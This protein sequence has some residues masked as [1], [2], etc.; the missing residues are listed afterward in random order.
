LKS[1]AAALSDDELSARRRSSHPPGLAALARW[2]VGRPAIPDRRPQLI[3]V[4]QMVFPLL[5]DHVQRD[6]RQQLPGKIA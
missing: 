3:E 6:E 2:V 1:V 4:I 5:V